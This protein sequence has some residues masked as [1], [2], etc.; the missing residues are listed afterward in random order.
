MAALSHARHE[1]RSERRVIAC[2]RRWRPHAVLRPGQHVTVL[3][4]SS[5]A[6]LMESDGQ[7]RPGAHR[8]LQLNAGGQRVSIKGRLVRC[9]V[10]A[11]EPLRY[12]GVLV[13][14][15]RMAIEHDEGPG[16]E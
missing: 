3:N 13:F 6:A 7:L 4:L 1:R 9:H 16:R 10:T 14:D 11:L 5:Q 12:R 2:G 8:E 15:H